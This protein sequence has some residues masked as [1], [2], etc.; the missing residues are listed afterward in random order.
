[1]NFIRCIRVE[2]RIVENDKQ[3][4][5][6]EYEST[7]SRNENNISFNCSRTM[8]ADGETE[9]CE[10]DIWGMNRGYRDIIVND[11][12]R[13]VVSLFVGYKNSDQQFQSVSL[14]RGGISRVWWTREGMDE[15]T[16][17]S[18]YCSAPVESQA[19]YHINS[20][21]EP[22]KDI[23]LGLAKSMTDDVYKYIDNR[24][25]YRVYANGEFGD[26]RVDSG[27]IDIARKT[28]NSKPHL[29]CGSFLNCM[30]E[31]AYS[32]GFTWTIQ[33]GMLYV[34]DD[35]SY[36]LRGI[37]FPY[38][39]DSHN[40]ISCEPILVDGIGMVQ[41]GIKVEALLDAAVLPGS[42]IE[43]NSAVYPQYGG[44]YMVHNAD[45]SGGVTG[46][47]WKMTLESKQ[48]RLD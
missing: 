18:L 16:T 25:Q 12:D 46:S 17:I 30:N 21:G 22:I 6:F 37:G 36:R 39:I 33:R 7:G 13:F 2:F 11:Y 44:R 24:I 29:L 19:T 8:V 5:R 10:I 27:S 4:I 9:K 38:L 14:F 43:V 40:L 41:S 32:Y 26:F 3:R 42:I 45:Y 1:M 15:K 28:T 20:G 47:D 48:C 34:F 31:L 35:T 23:I